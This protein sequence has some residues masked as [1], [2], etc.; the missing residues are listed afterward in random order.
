M[1]NKRLVFIEDCDGEEF[2]L[3]YP[4]F[5]QFVLL[6]QLTKGG[7][8]LTLK[9]VIAIIRDQQPIALID[10]VTTEQYNVTEIS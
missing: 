7:G 5:V 3:T 1:R 6:N 10:P 9:K 2:I 4:E 8:S